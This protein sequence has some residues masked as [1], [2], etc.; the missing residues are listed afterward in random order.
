MLRREGV[1]TSSIL[2]KIASFK[3][4]FTFLHD[5]QCIKENPIHNITVK[6]SDNPLPKILS[7]EEMQKI[8]KYFDRG[9]STLRL[10]VML[11]ILYGAGLRVT[12]LVTMQL[13]S[14]IINQETNRMTLLI[15]GK[16]G[17]ERI[18]PMNEYAR[19]VI[20]NYLTQRNRQPKKNA[21]LFPSR[22][23]L[24]HLTRQGFAKT[25]KKLAQAVG[26]QSSKISP[27]VIR[28]AFATHLLANGAD[29]LTIQKLL[30]HQDVSTTQI[31]THVANSRLAQIVETNPKLEKIDIISS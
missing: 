15:K 31:Y 8:I 7:Q 6:K 3:N 5:E 25:I 18:I 13:D 23:K 11:H 30:G 19:T 22:G 16:G 4:F 24:G 2:R 10:Q 20:M 29:I 27:H 14:V 26:I 28:H 9:K 1:K 17:K 21:Y 12:E